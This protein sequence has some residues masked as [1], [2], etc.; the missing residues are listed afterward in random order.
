MK[1]NEITSGIN[2]S[3]VT[4]PASVSRIR[5][6]GERSTEVTDGVSSKFCSAGTVEIDIK[7][8]PDSECWRLG[9]GFAAPRREE[10]SG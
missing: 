6:F 2:A 8:F 4:S 1:E 5:T 7:V 9:A 10:C 3:A